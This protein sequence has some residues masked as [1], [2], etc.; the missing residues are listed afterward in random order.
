MPRSRL[1]IG[2]S[3]GARHH[4]AH[5]QLGDG[6]DGR[7]RV[8]EVE[9]ELRRVADVPDH[10]EGDVDDVLVAGQHQPGAGAAHRAGADLLGVL[11]RH[12]HDLVG[13]DRP[14][15]EVQAGLAD[16]VA[17]AFAE[18]ELDR[19][20]LGPHGVERHQHPEPDERR[21]GDGEAAP[22]ERRRRRRPCRAA[23]AAGRGRPSGSGAAPA[24]CGR[25]R[26]CRAPAAAARAALLPRSPPPQGPRPPPFLSS[27]PPPPPPQGPPLLL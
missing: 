24:P 22:A 18:G 12:L 21:A 10:L 4:L 20:L 13:D 15:R 8:R 11:A 25:S 3:C 6:L 1:R 23:A 5:R 16:A 19:L 9:E 26:R 14:G 17:A 27:P 7:G 2:E